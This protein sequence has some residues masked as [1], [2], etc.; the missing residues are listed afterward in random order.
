MLSVI[1]LMGKMIGYVFH[2][3][4]STSSVHD[5][6]LGKVPTNYDAVTSMNLQEV[7]DHL[8]PTTHS[9][10]TKLEHFLKKIF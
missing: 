4:S 1:V 9:I 10:I 2:L 3:C 6:Q 5:Q 7:I 8:F